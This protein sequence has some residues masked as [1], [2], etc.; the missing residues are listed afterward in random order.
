MYIPKHFKEEELLDILT[1][2]SNCYEKEMKQPWNMEASKGYIQQ[3]LK[4]IAVKYM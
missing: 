1:V 2:S 4:D 3:L